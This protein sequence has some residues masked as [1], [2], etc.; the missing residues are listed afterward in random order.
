MM[1]LK[2]ATVLVFSLAA[3][4]A[5][6]TVYGGERRYPIAP[7][8]VLDFGGALS[9]RGDARSEKETTGSS[10]DTTEERDS[11]FEESL[12]LRS[13]GYLY[14]PN[15]FD[16]DLAARLGLNQERISIDDLNMDT[17][18]KLLGYS[19]GGVVLREKPVSF[20]V[21]SSASQDV[22]T[23][24]FARSA[25]LDSRQNTLEVFSKGRF[26]MSL[27][28]EASELNEI[29]DPRDDLK[30][31]GYARYS[32]TDRR[33]LDWFTELVLERED[34]DETTV[35]T[36]SGGGQS[37]TQDLSLKRNEMN[38]SARWKFGPEGKKHSFNNRLRVLDRTGF[39][40]DRIFSNQAELTLAHTKTFSTFYRLLL[41]DDTSDVEM[42][43]T[44]I[45]EAGFSKSI[46]ES[47]N[48][49]GRLISTR[50]TFEA[51]SEEIVGAFLDLQYRKR[52][53]IG[54]YDSSLLRGREE[55]KEE[56]DTEARVV[57]GRS[58]ALSDITYVSLGE[59]Q[60]IPGS[61]TVMNRSRTIVYVAGGAAPDYAI[62]RTGNLTEIARLV[63][64]R[65]LDG[66]IVLVDFRV[67]T[68]REAF[69]K[70]DTVGWTNRLDLKALPLAVYFNTRTRD[71]KL[72]S[73][74][75]PGNLD[76]ETLRLLGVELDH[77]G[78]TVA[79]ERERREHRLFPSSTADRL[80]GRY[81]GRFGRNTSFSLSGLTEQLIYDDAA[82]FDFEPGRDQLKT[83]RGNANLST[84]IGRNSL[85]NFDAE[86]VRTEGRENNE[87]VRLS[88]SFDWSYRDLDFSIEARH[89][90]YQQELNEGTSDA[91]LFN[92]TRRF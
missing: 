54:N 30:K 11:F 32:V 70:T 12:E 66:E 23:R 76:L 8:R 16:W 81:R 67:R 60:I 31:T 89:N 49:S 1:C 73:G 72:S 29:G 18:G 46:Y 61:I 77:K 38:L 13:R 71:E 53:A 14:H 52:T 19:L 44:A 85:L 42:E 79:V 68:A 22:L 56:I 58:V 4:A 86:F 24:D 34:T 78:L 90:I 62:R 20:R 43:K 82:A 27:R 5:S 59:E 57:L 55:E 88:V 50:R 74:D 91:V 80:R 33:N 3:L 7:V 2:R 45:G 83:L 25:T 51:S 40:P 64:G 87:L 92:I 10:E 21:H 6:H 15:L 48:V 75:D 69:F 39:F 41:N 28:L 63:T 35:F 84:K 47:L 36:Q 17:D 26:P 37:T 65:I 9:L